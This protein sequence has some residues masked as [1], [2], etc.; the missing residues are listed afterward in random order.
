MT[1]SGASCCWVEGEW[2]IAVDADLTRGVLCY[3]SPDYTAALST[4]KE[5]ETYPLW[6][7]IPD[8]GTL[9]SLRC[10]IPQV[11]TPWPAPSN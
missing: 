11:E 2:F 6:S 7:P 8:S 9:P 1:E 5:L 4:S 3:N 10:T